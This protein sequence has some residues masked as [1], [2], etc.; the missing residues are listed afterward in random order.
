MDRRD[1]LKAA[2][3]TFGWVD[4]VLNNAGVMD[5]AF[6]GDP[7][8]YEAQRD[9]VFARLHESTDA[10]WE[11][12]IRTTFY[13]SYRNLRAELKQMLA[14]GRGGSIVNA[15]SIAGLTDL[16]GNPAYVATKHAVNGMT[17]NAVI[18]YAPFG[19]RVISINMAATDTPMIARAA[20][21]VAASAAVV[22][23]PAMGRIKTQSILA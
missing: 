19:I 1:V 18:D 20:T 5:A 7:P 2:V 9:L 10:Y 12:V 21:M 14:Q 6:P 22:Q 11:G 4:C 3:D 13:G 15:G 23:G 16:V 17:R 8:D